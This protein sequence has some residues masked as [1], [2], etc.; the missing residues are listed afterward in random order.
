[1]FFTEVS[2]GNPLKK[3]VKHT[4]TDDLLWEE[5]SVDEDDNPFDYTGFSFQ[6][7]IKEFAGDDTAVVTIPDSSFTITQS[8]DGADA[9][10]NDMWLIEHPP[11][12]FSDLIAEPFE[13]YYDIQITDAAGKKFTPIKGPFLIEAD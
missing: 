3:K 4:R 1:M 9:G 2:P 5:Q 6:L 7:E 11:D 13:Y 8:S 12:D 10:V